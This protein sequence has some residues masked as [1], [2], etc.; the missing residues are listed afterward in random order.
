MKKTLLKMFMLTAI[1]AVFGC[2]SAFAQSD[3][4]RAVTLRLR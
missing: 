2:V 3:D 4:E 1:F